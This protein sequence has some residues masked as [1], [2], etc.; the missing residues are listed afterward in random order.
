MRVYLYQNLIII[1]LIVVF[2]FFVI[3]FLLFKTYIYYC[4]YWKNK[5][6]RIK[7]FFRGNVAA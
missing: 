1:L 6:G 7:F 4:I 5:M 3:K 2:S